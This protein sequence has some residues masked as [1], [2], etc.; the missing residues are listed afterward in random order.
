MKNKPL[1]D[2]PKDSHNWKYIVIWGPRFWLKVFLPLYLAFHKKPSVYLAPAHYSPS[3]PSLKL[4]TVIHDLAYLYFPEDFLKKDLYKLTKWTKEALEKSEKVICVSN[5]TKNDIGK[6]YPKYFDKSLVVYNG[7][8]S[9]T[10]LVVENDNLKKWT[11]SPYILY[12]GTLQARKNLAVLIQ[13]FSF[14]K[15]DFKDLK[16]VIVGKKG[17]LYE[18]LFKKII[19]L[20]LEGEVIFTGFIS[21]DEKNYL[22]SK[23]KTFVLPSKYEGF[24]L[25]ILEAMS[26]LCP[27]VV[28]DNSS[29]REIGGE[30]ALYAQTTSPASFAQQIKRILLD[31]NLKVNLQKT[32]QKQILKFNFLTMSRKYFDI[33]L[34]ICNS[35]KDGDNY[36]N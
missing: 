17:W 32:G 33:L 4:V 30:A 35:N 2:M 10:A 29:T 23:A 12:V 16:L 28:A 36:S 34:D 20:H 26:Y 25:P 11:K 9:P 7:I 31:N 5:S 18:E 13:A 8:A 21:Q 24:G 15:K 6:F 14:L 19:E 22:Y 3:F 1:G 27:V